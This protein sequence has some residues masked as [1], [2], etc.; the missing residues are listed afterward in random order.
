MTTL[1]PEMARLDEYLSGL[2]GEPTQIIAVRPLGGEVV[3]ASR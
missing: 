1:A 3:G 2:L